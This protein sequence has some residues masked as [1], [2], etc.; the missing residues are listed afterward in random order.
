MLPRPPP[1]PQ[2]PGP[3]SAFRSWSRAA[4]DPRSLAAYE[5]Q[6]LG[7]VAD[8]DRA[9]L[10]QKAT[11]YLVETYRRVQPSFRFQWT[12]P[13]RCLTRPPEPAYNDGYDNRTHDYI[14]YVNDVLCDPT[15]REEYLVLDMLGTG[16]FGQ[17]V[18]CFHKPS[19]SNVA[20]KIVKNQPAYFNQAWVEI[21]ILRMLHTQNSED[22]TRH[23]VRFLKY[24]VFRNH[25]CLVFEK[26]HI[27]LYEL[28][29]Q[30]RY[31]GLTMTML[32]SF[33][34]Q[35]L[36][37]LDVL[38]RSEVVHCDVKPENILLNPHDTTKL[39][40]I[41]F[42]SA[43]QVSH[44]VY[45]YVQSRFYRSPEILLGLPEYDS[46]IDMWSLGCV[47]G[48]LFLGIPIFPGPNAM[49]MLCRISEMVGDF[50]DMFLRRCR[51]SRRY[52]KEVNRLRSDGS[53]QVFQLKSVEE[54]EAENN[55]TLPAWRRYFTEHR[56]RD[57]IMASAFRPHVPRTEE[58][59]L[60]E[61]LIDLLGGMLKIDP[62]ERWT[63]AEALQ[64]PFIVSG[65]LHDG[66]PW[67]PPT[68]HRR[69]SLPRTRPMPI[70]SGMADDE[71]DSCF[72][73]SAPSFAGRGPFAPSTFSSQTSRP[74]P[75]GSSTIAASTGAAS[76]VPTP[77]FA[78]YAP[79]RSHPTEGNHGNRRP[80]RAVF[81][82]IAEEGDFDDVMAEEAS[83]ET[84]HES[85]S[86]HRNHGF[87]LRQEAGPAAFASLTRH[88]R[89]TRT[90]SMENMT[91]RVFSP[92]NRALG[93][94]ADPTSMGSTSDEMLPTNNDNTASFAQSA[95]H[96]EDVVFGLD[97]D[98]EPSGSENDENPAPMG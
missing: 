94:A 29:R 41:D 38:V 5:G 66:R 80:G 52:F 25:L 87:A 31:E 28:L 98:D 14:L 63:P 86:E 78:A 71:P 27:N 65:P 36:L 42:G 76:Y 24:F 4:N 10:L 6:A 59:A 35:L 50:P 89:Q 16:T 90:T 15:T 30:N 67:Q 9:S 8:E 58:I 75:A 56:L 51:H 17:V 92:H 7:A 93:E 32:R 61:S 85:D 96:N 12:V 69:P 49:N 39:K 77:A 37:A 1:P 68:R 53:V 2:L 23:I 46:K 70:D 84:G 81:P 82:P 44:N 26:L 57:I 91:E 47:T 11:V 3:C 97:A 55:Q 62:A 34:R 19:A 54:Y 13:R 72:S 22:D 95:A 33:V 43:C 21:N 40:L 48:E 83:R 64:H 74:G 79:S 20:V 18:R 60:R 88:S 73:A 45:S